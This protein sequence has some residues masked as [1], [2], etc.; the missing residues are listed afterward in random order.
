VLPTFK[1]AGDVDHSLTNWP[2]FAL[3]IQPK[4][5]LPLNLLISMLAALTKGLETEDS[6]AKNDD[7]EG[8]R[9]EKYQDQKP[10]D[11]LK[12]VAREK[13][14][15]CSA[16]G[17]NMSFSRQGDLNRHAKKHCPLQ[18]PC[19]FPDRGAVFNRK[20][21]LRGH[22]VKGHE[23]NSQPTALSSGRPRKDRDEDGN[24]R[25]SGFSGRDGS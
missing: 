16:Q 19:T 23:G 1:M 13:P 15:Q 18:F 10:L 3:T 24:S 17:C 8:D 25:S 5:D 9:L 12:H 4:V 11:S 22:W 20:D 2:K 21:K 6:I 7:I 14:Y